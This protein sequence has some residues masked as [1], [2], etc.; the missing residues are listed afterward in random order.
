MLLF[1]EQRGE[2]LLFLFLSR[3]PLVGFEQSQKV[4]AEKENQSLGDLWLGTAKEGLRESEIIREIAERRELTGGIP[5]SS[6]LTFGLTSELLIVDLILNS[7]PTA[8]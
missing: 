1:Q 6:I 7:M 3:L 5:Q 2:T 4:S 8:L